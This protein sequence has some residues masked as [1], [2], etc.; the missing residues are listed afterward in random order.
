MTISQE[1]ENVTNLYS[2]LLS[3]STIAEPRGPGRN[4]SNIDTIKKQ[5]L[6]TTSRRFSIIR[7]YNL[8]PKRGDVLLLPK[9]CREFNVDILKSLFIGCD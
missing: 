1:N 3:S 7:V 2:I 4:K 6:N 9:I 8:F 5:S